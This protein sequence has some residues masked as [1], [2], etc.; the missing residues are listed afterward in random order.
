MRNSDDNYTLPETFLD[1]DEAP[2]ATYDDRGNSLEYSLSQEPNRSQVHNTVPLAH[3]ASLRQQPG[4][5]PSSPRSGQHLNPRNH[6]LFRSRTPSRPSIRATED[7]TNQISAQAQNPVFR[8][9]PQ[10]Y[11][12]HLTEIAA[13]PPVNDPSQREDQTSIEKPTEPKSQTSEMAIQAYTI[14]YLIFFSI[15]GTLARLGLQAL[16]TYPGAPAT[17]GV[18]WANVG[19]SL[20]MGFLAEDRQMFQEPWGSASPSRT[21]L[22]PIEQSKRYAAFKKTIPLYIGLSTGFCGCLTSFSSWQRDSFLALANAAT[23]TGNS[24]SNAPIPRNGGYSFLALLATL[25]L[26][27]TLC[28]GALQVGAHVALGLQSVTPKVNAT[29][30]RKIVDPAMIPLAFL[31]WL[32]AIFLAIWPPDRPFGSSAHATWLNETWRGDAIFACVFAPLG[33]LTRFYI[34]ILLNGRMPSFPLGTFVVNIFGSILEGMFY[35]L[36]HVRLAAGIG[37]GLVSCQVLQGLMDGYCGSTTTISTWVAELKGL[38]RR[39]AYIYGG[40]S[41]F[42]GLAFMIV[43]MGSAFWTDGYQATACGK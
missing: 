41:M 4:Q 40:A 34:S 37:G 5:L 21:T 6:S 16:T 42:T 9:P 20:I 30:T 26:T 10:G 35:D 1:L 36:Q 14:S 17:Q 13:P 29:I 18:L 31:S 19:G 3:N 7:D 39:H 38:R 15:W 27:P 23:I 12:G 25:I 43:I 2:P 33:C 22:P 24:V 8:N 11:H 28:L 32:G